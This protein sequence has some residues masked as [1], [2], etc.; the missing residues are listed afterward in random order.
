[1]PIL[2]VSQPIRLTIVLH[3]NNSVTVEGPLAD[4]ALC[5]ALLN[6]ALDIVRNWHR[7]LMV[8]PNGQD[9]VS[10]PGKDVDAPASEGW[11]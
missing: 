6:N 8:L 4:K 7:P 1:M 2:D 5:V 9:G 3:P 11:T 10:A